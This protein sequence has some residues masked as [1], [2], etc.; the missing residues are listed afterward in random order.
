MLNVLPEEVWKR[1]EDRYWDWI[2]WEY[3]YSKAMYMCKTRFSKAGTGHFGSVRESFRMNA[4]DRSMGVL[5][6][7]RD[8]KGYIRGVKD[9]R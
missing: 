2:R 7:S 5:N 8:D 3:V 4:Q 1:Y 6:D 9:E